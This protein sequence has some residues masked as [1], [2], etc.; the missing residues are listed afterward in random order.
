MARPL[1]HPFNELRA[2]GDSVTVNVGKSVIQLAKRYA[3]RNGFAVTATREQAE[4]GPVIRITRKDPS[5][6]P[7]AA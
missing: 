6:A 4:T 2:D 5:D 1:T 7:Q 3:A